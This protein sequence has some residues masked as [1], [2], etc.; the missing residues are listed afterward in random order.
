MSFFIRLIE[1]DSKSCNSLT[2]AANNS[3]HSRKSSD[4][5][6]LSLGQS[7]DKGSEQETEED[8][9]INW[10]NTLYILERSE[11]KMYFY[12]LI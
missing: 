12:N 1:S 2:G 6:E 9:W 10:G 3:T 11:E 5:S 7:S 4:T 8:L